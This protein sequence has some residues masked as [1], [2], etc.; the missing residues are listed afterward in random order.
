MSPLKEQ[1]GDFKLTNENSNAP[2]NGDLQD[3]FL[4]LENG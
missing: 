2:I 4:E 1:D 3:I